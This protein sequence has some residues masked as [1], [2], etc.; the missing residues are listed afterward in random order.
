MVKKYELEDSSG[1]LIYMINQSM[2]GFFKQKLDSEDVNVVEAWIML[3]ILN[4]LKTVSELTSVLKVDMA[5]IH[6][7]CDRLRKK[8]LI[9]RK[10]DEHDKRIKILD[11]TEEGR[12][13]KLRISQYS[14][15]VNRR[16]LSVLDEKERQQLYQL[17]MKV[18]QGPFCSDKFSENS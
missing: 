8:G 18:E 7:H 2:Y 15:E 4:G 5:L 17:L 12:K 3:Q 16:A 11:L 14:K 1:Y 10:V 6:R 9:T 13:L